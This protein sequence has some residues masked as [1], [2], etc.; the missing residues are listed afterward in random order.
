[1]ICS[2]EG[3]LFEYGSDDEIESNLRVLRAFPQLVAVV[4]SVTRSDQPVQQ[5]RKATTP[6][7]RPRG[8]PVFAALTSR[9]GWKIQ[10]ATERPFS[11]Q[12]V[13]L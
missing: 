9:A 1:M 11:D 6:K 8:L 7:T 3:G 2:S 5:L 12:V 13:P 10:R 4:G